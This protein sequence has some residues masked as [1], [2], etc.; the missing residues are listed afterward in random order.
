MAKTPPTKTR[1]VQTGPRDLEILLAAD[2]CPLTIA[3][4]LRVSQTFERPFT[5][6]HHL[7]RRVRQ[8]RSAGLL[9]AFPYAIANGGRSPDYLRITQAGYR[10]LHGPEAKTKRR[11]FEAVSPAQHLHTHDL[12]E[13]VS[14]LLASAHTAGADVTHFMR[15]GSLRI[16]NDR[17]AAFPDCAFRLESPERSLNYYVELDRGT[18]RIRT[19]QDVESILRKVH[20]Y[21]ID[22]ARFDARDPNRPLVLFVTTRTNLRRDSILAAAAKGMRN[23]NRTVFLAATLSDVCGGNPVTEPLFRDHRG[24][25][26][27]LLAL[28][29][30][31]RDPL[32]ESSRPGVD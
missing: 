5:D 12:S 16:G 27:P 25:G 19:K 32:R 23:P 14:H 8:L 26:R 11:H 7:R 29:K 18:E 31:L 4:L 2:R 1:P 10:L 21:D 3:Q 22:N 20:A 9:K 24:Q 30:K 15:E 6:S 28:P 13:L 17:V